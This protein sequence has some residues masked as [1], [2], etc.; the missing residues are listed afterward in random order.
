MTGKRGA[1]RWGRRQ[2]VQLGAVG[3]AW[4]L[5][6][7]GGG[8]SGGGERPQ[9][10]AA[11]PGGAI[12]AEAT[13]TATAKR[14][15]TVKYVS[16]GSPS[17]LD[18]YTQ[19][20]GNPL[21]IVGPVYSGLLG[22]RIDENFNVQLM[23]DLA[24]KWEQPDPQSYVFKLRSGVKWHNVAPTNGRALATDDV[25]FS[26]KRGAEG[27]PRP[28][29]SQ[30]DGVD[31]I[32]FP[33]AST[34][35][36]TLKQ[37]TA[38]FIYWMADPYNVI[39]PKEAT[40]DLL[41]TKAAG[42]GPFILQDYRAEVGSAVVR[43]PD[44]FVSGQPSLDRIDCA[45]MP[46]QD[47]MLTAMRGGNLDISASSAGGYLRIPQI[48]QVKQSV[49]RA[50][51]FRIPNLNVGHIR[52]NL[53]RGP[54]KDE[55]VRKA[56]DLVQ[57]DKTWLDALAFGDGK[58]TPP[59][60]WG[61][62]KW[63]LPESELPKR[64]D[65]QQARQLLAAAGLSGTTE[66]VNVS[67]G[68]PPSAQT[69]QGIAIL[70]ETLKPLGFKITTKNLDT[71]AWLD[72]LIKKDFD[73]NLITG[74]L[75]FTEPGTY[76]ETYFWDKGGRGYTKHNDATLNDLIEKQRS[77]VNE[78]ERVKVIQDVQR[79]VMEKTYYSMLFA[80]FINIGYQPYVKNFRLDF[81]HGGNL[82]YWGEIWLDK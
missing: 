16:I 60:P 22:R 80:D 82:R 9:T 33:D 28:R 40:D 36:V 49:P 39:L 1:A 57:D 69:T 41:K 12:R 32:E 29:K 8:G 3:T 66:V 55:R 43:N 77:M 48:D 10:S 75:G 76:V 38:E 19:S 21:Y 59:V 46:D 5:A 4:L 7:C 30:F 13:S 50:Q 15:G 18:L 79:R 78:A 64:P 11:T 68:A 72:A 2:V 37:P 20:T 24:E 23:A 27:S 56:V 53:E 73:L 71:A 31:K 62:G 34:V 47:T 54:F 70:E 58:R 81:L 42:T 6:A 65:V 61:L 67:L 35:R 14:G 44:Y 17:N 25:Q 45:I 52:F 26:F 74:V 63:A 51:F